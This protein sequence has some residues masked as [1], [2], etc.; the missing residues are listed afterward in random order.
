MVTEWGFHSH[1]GTRKWMVYKENPT[2]IDDLGGPR[3]P[4]VSL[5]PERLSESCDM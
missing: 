5:G 1:G 4:H 3:T 2:R